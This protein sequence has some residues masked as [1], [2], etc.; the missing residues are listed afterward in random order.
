MVPLFLPA[1][2][3][4]ARSALWLVNRVESGGFDKIT[5]VPVN[6]TL[7]PAAVRGGW[8]LLCFGG[9]PSGRCSGTGTPGSELLFRA[10][11]HIS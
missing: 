5:G 6:W 2:T 9:F 4:L 3:E 8:F 10:S 11:R 7:D 1:A